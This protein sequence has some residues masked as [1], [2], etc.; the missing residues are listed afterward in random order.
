MLLTQIDYS[1]I[2]TDKQARKP[3]HNV[4]YQGTS[5]IFKTT[6]DLG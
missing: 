2:L 6:Q 3:D 5:G 4:L 1:C